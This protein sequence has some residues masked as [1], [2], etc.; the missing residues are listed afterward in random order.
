MGSMDQARPWLERTLYDSYHRERVIYEG[1]VVR[2][3]EDF[4]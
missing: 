4:Q 3:E 1:A 2:E